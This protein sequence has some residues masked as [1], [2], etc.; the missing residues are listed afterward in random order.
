MKFQHSFTVCRKLRCQHLSCRRR[1]CMK[2]AAA[3]GTRRVDEPHKSLCKHSER[4]DSSAS[5]LSDTNQC[6]GSRSERVNRFS[7][8]ETMTL[9]SEQQQRWDVPF[10]EINCHY[11]PVCPKIFNLNHVI[12]ST[13]CDTEP[14]IVKYKIHIVFL[15]FYPL[16]L[17]CLTC[18]TIWSVPHFS[19]PWFGFWL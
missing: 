19:Q 4:T 11:S 2:S 14:Y 9:I 6:A 5:T 7:W 13:D 1:R 16:R 17:K 15:F 10:K 12:I 18:R 8:T 3:S